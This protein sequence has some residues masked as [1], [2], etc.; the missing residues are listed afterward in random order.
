MKERRGGLPPTC[1]LGAPMLRAQRTL[2][3]IFNLL[4]SQTRIVERGGEKIVVKDYSKPM[5]LIK[6][7]ITLFPPISTYYPFET[8]PLER[9][10][11]ETRFFETP[12]RGVGVPRVLRVDPQELV[13]EREFIEGQ[14]YYDNPREHSYHIGRTLGEV[15]RQDYCLGDTKPDN[16]VLS[17]SGKVYIVDA[18][19]SLLKCEFEEYKT[20]DIMVFLAFLYLVEPIQTMSMYRELVKR[21]LKGYTER[22]ELKAR[23]ARNL[24]PVSY[25]LPVTHALVFRR[26]VM[27]HAT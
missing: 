25:V 14:T 4:I 5:G 12:P 1:E 9:M 11:R 18:E 17:P 6:W 26:A 3:S 10:L 13:M 27:E 2:S 19:Q 8:D 15:H 21:A 23:L 24:M 22:Y 20:W 7:M 16:F